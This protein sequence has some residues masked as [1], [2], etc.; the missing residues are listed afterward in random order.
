LGVLDGCHPDVAQVTRAYRLPSLFASLAEHGEQD[1]GEDRDY[2]DHHQ[3]LNERE[4]Y[5]M[6]QHGR[7]STNEG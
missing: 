3:Q 5:T 2:R 1:G 4:A 6:R 7:N